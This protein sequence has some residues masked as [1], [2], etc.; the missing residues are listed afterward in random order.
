MQKFR[1]KSACHVASVSNISAP[2]PATDLCN[3]SFDLSDR[4][5]RDLC[6]IQMIS[7]NALRVNHSETF[8]ASYEER[9]YRLPAINCFLYRGP[10]CEPKQK[11]NIGNCSLIPENG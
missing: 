2:R 11:K 7:M 4:S 8:V 9:I 5:N 1:L 6:N 10:I 3:H